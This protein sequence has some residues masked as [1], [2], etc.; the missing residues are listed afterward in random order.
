MNTTPARRVITGVDTD[1]QSVIESDGPATNVVSPLP[2]LV[3]HQVWQ[4]SSMPAPVLAPDASAAIRGVEPPKNGTV[5]RVL[6]IPPIGTM[7]KDRA[8]VEKSFES[9]G[10][11]HATVRSDRTANMHKT[12]TVDYGI[13]IMGELTLIL[14][15]GETT[16]YP[17]D[18][19][20]QRGTVH[21]WE[22]RGKAPCRIVFVLID[23]VEP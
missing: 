14:D 10:A 11:S 15:R 22:N 16:L 18:I 3:F 2:N 4:T 7:P 8:T 20:V 21:G 13:V 9:L 12:V 19:C 5:I 23:G 6:D 1:G 17:G